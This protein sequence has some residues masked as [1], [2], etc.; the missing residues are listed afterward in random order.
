MPQI[1]P[2]RI[3]A[4]RRE[5]EPIGADDWLKFSEQESIQIRVSIDPYSAVYPSLLV[6]FSGIQSVNWN[7]AVLALHIVYGWMPTVRRL[8]R[9]REW[10]SSKQGELIKALENAR[11]G[12]E[13]TPKELETIKGFCNNSMVGASKLLHFLE[14]DA[15]P[16][17][18]SRVAR[19]FLRRRRLGASAINKIARWTAY[20][21]ALKRWARMDACGQGARNCA[22][23]TVVCVMSLTCA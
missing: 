19:T 16:I 13:L 12:R 10:D 23:A 6:H 8:D 18:D 1:R 22:N 2:P 4:K 9:I 3:M 11:A 15:F 7:S 20:R 17:W 5:R 21:D 14:P